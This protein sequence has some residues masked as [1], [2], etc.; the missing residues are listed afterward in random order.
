MPTSGKPLDDWNDESETKEARSVSQPPS[1]RMAPAYRLTGLRPSSVPPP[2]EEDILRTIAD[3][4]LA[5]A[6]ADGE[7]CTREMRTI[8][9]I[10]SDLADSDALPPWLEL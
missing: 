10:L 4:L 9:R 2:P 1:S 3:V 7:V 6:H 8:R 5:A